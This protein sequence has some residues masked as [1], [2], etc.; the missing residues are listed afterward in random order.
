LAD[1]TLAHVWR[2]AETIEAVAY[3]TPVVGWRAKHVNTLRLWSARAPD[4]LRLDAFNAGDYVGAQA[5]QMRAESISKVLYPSDSTPAGQELRLRQEYFFASASLQDLIRRHMK[6]SGDIGK[7]SDK[8][9]IQLN[10]THPAI[11]VAELMRLLVDVHGVPWKDAWTIT[12]ATF[13]Y[14]NHTLLPEALETWP[15]GLMERLLPRHVQIIYL[16]NALHLDALRDRGVSD[17]GALSNVS[18]IDEYNGR[19]VRMGNLAF[20]GSHKVNGVSALHSELVKETVFRDFHKLY[21]DRIVNKT[22]GVTFRRWLLEAN[23]PLSNLLAQD[24]PASVRRSVPPRRAG[25]IR[26]RSGLPAAL[27]R[28]QAEQQGAT[29]E[30]DFR[31]H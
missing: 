23:P 21:P 7:L 6:Q 18:L 12:Q 25:A 17:A 11:G 5:D 16:I 19:H 4:P 14:T 31:A 3:D 26:R 9:A 24:R 22:N 29:G 28:R 2:P 13:S 15:V 20:L 1:G 30:T 8:V 27:R 10:D